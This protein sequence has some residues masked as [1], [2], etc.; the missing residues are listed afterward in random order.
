MGS[1]VTDLL[2][3]V[4]L[5]APAILG[6]ILYAIK[7]LSAFDLELRTHRQQARLRYIEASDETADH[8]RELAIYQKVFAKAT[9]ADGHG[10]DFE[11]LARIV[12]ADSVARRL[13]V[14]YSTRIEPH[15]A[16]TERSALGN[17]VRNDVP[18]CVLALLTSD[19]A[20]R[21]NQ[22][23]AAHLHQRI[24]DGEIREARIDRRRLIRRAIVMAMTGRVHRARARLHDDR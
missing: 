2:I 18:L 20:K 5:G 17:R 11:D 10:K 24:Q 8:F 6:A 14:T 21:Y 19:D 12:R 1:K 15:G 22:E 13:F 23:W 3:P 16:N 7:R 9:V 4:S